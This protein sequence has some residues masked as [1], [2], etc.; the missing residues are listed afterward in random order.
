LPTNGAWERVAIWG[1]AAAVTVAGVVVCEP[2]L[3]RRL[4]KLLIEIGE[5]S[6]SLYLTH[7]FVLPVIGVVL[8]KSG[9]TDSPLAIVLIVSCLVM[10]TLTSLFIYRWI[11]APMTNSLRR[12]VQERALW[13]KK[14]SRVFRRL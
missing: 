13:R 11:E 9:I 7:G 5:A 4:P 14:R 1:S 8:A 3:G 12:M 6:Y 10:S 2:W